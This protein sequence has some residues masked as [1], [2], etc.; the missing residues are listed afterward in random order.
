MTYSE[1][2]LDQLEAGKLKEAQNSFKLALINDDD[3]ILFSLAEEL[4][5]LGFLQ[6]AR[7]IYLKLLDCYPD[8]DELKTNLATIAIDEGHNDEALSYLAQIK[9][10]SP[11]YVQSLLVAADLYQTE[12]EFEVTE[13]K[14]KEAYA[15]APDEPAVE[16]ALGE[17]YF[18]VGQ[19]SEA[20]QYYFQ[21]IKN[22]YTDFAKV[23]IAGR[24]GICYAQSGQFKKALGYF[25]QV[26]PEYQTSDIRF[27]KGLTRLQLGDTEKAI[28]TLEDLINDDNQYA[29]AYPELAKAY[30]K[31]NKYQ[32]ALRVV[33]EGLSVDQYNEYLY[34]LAAEN[35]SYL[36]DQKLMKKYLVK[37]H[38]L[39]PE[40]M[41]ITLQYS[42]FLLHQHDD[43]AN[44]K[45]LSPLVKEDETDPQLYWNLAR[46]YQRTDQLELAGKYYEAALPAY[47]ENPTF[48]KELINYYRETGET[49][50]LMD[51]LERYLRLVPTDTEM[52]DLYDQYEDY[53]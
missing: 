33:Q 7:T 21:L 35:T 8:E 32:Q 22:G 4:Y 38:E 42:N 41:T 20:I 2:M 19:Y 11:A 48:L 49:D 9:P 50:K 51:E 29:S 17:F 18:M 47:S 27:Q 10:D 25:N 46:S 31:E 37:A 23:D 36:G 26:K 40:N 13:E 52:Q 30:E 39:A 43:E 45:L 24:L 12:E 16:F 1:Q 28:K 3:D 34:S 5:A 44:I 6:Q 14:L 53:K 15:L